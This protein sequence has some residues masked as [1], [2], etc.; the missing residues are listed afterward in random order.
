MPRV[1]HVKKARRDY[2]EDGIK[3]GESYFWWKFRYCSKS[4]SKSRPTPQQLTRSEFWSQVYD[5]QDELSDCSDS[6]TLQDIIERIR[7][8]AD[9]QEEKRNNMPESLQ[10]VGSGEILMNRT[11]AL[12]DWADELEDLDMDDEAFDFDDIPS[13]SGE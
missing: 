2:P 10:E 8:F 5:F 4:R 3:R 11:E 6:D 1:H 7:E 12:T 9:E 13:Y